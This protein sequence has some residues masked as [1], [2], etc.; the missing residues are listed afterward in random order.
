MPS[1]THLSRQFDAVLN[2]FKAMDLGMSDAERYPSGLSCGYDPK[3]KTYPSIY[4]SGPK[5]EFAELPDSGEAVI[6]YQVTRRSTEEENGK[7]RHSLTLEVRSID[8]AASKKAAEAKKAE[9]RAVAIA[10]SNGEGRM[11][12][13]AGGYHRDEEGG[14]RKQKG[15]LAH[16]KRNAVTYA[17]TPLAPIGWVAG[18]A[19]DRLYRRPR[20]L[21]KSAKESPRKGDGARVGG[22]LPDGRVSTEFNRPRDGDGQFVANVT[23]G[24]DPVTMRQAYGPDPKKSKLLAPGA[25]AAALAGTAGLLGT[26]SGRVMA[27][28]GAKGAS[29]MVRSAVTGIDRKLKGRSTERYPIMGSKAPKGKPGLGE[30][31]MRQQM[32]GD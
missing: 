19:V 15:V 9:G 22:V 20:N 14:I 4:L 1:L 28:K 21:K 17:G 3:K 10:M 25:A 13:F 29:R 31:L 27:I 24:A 26:K 2:Q 23:G 8:P 18:A 7:K 12:N 16:L 5:D 32:R 6:K 30:T 11:T